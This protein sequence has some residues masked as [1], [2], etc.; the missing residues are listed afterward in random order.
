MKTI[1][2]YL[3]YPWKFPDSSYY[4][5][6]VE[7]P[8]QNV[9]YLNINNQKGAITNKKIFWFSNFIK[10]VVRQTFNFLN[11]SIPNAHLSPQGDYDLIHCC[12]CLSKNKDKPWVADCEGVWQ[13]YVGNKTKEAKERVRQILI[14]KNCKKILAWTRATAKD[15]I[16]EFPEIKNKVEVVYPAISV[17]EFNKNKNKK[18][19]ILYAT[20]Y[21]WLKGGI[22]ALE[23]YKKLKEKYKNKIKLIFISDVPKKIKKK[24]FE[25]EIMDLVPQEKLFEYYKKSDIFFYPSFMDT[26]GFG[27]LEA[28]SFGLPIITINTK[29]TKSRKEIIKNN[30]NGLVFDVEDSIT[31]KIINNKE[32]LIM[33]KD[34][35]KIINKLFK[36][37]CKLIENES[38]RIKLGKEGLKQIRFGKF[39]IKERNKKLEKIYE[40]ALK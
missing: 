6:L 18:I 8:P 5:Y 36:N 26:F 10:K 14:S 15:I 38:L 39:S 33:G 34:E 19:T 13:F 32:K 25:I 21:F 1:K 22:I 35:I 9:K 30:K 16:K 20:R 37:C 17:Q 2:V 7:N 24:Y 4:K 23:V 3:Q 31:D 12:H 27:L 11:F 29:Y 28:M 40:E